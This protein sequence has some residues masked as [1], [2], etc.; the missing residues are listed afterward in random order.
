V[1]KVTVLLFKYRI[2]LTFVIVAFL[3]TVTGNV[4]ADRTIV[5]ILGYC[6]AMTVFTFVAPTTNVVPVSD[7]DTAPLGTDAALA[8]LILNPRV[9]LPDVIVSWLFAIG[10]TLTVSL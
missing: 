10:E 3:G 8:T 1:P 9:V 7:I 5:E 4:I 2:K 6:P